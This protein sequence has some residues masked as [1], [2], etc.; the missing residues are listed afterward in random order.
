MKKIRKRI[1]KYVV[2]LLCFGI[3]VLVSA[4][5]RAKEKEPVSTARMYL[6]AAVNAGNGDGYS[7][8]NEIDIDD[9]HYNWKLGEFY[10]GGFTRVID[11]KSGSPIFLKNVGDKVKL[12]FI[13]NQDIDKLNGNDE[14]SIEQDENGYDEHFGIPKT[15]FGKGMLVIRHTNYQH[16]TEEPVLHKNYLESVKVKTDTEV[17]LCEEGDYEVALDYEIDVDNGIQFWKQGTYDYRIYFKFS[18]RNG[19]CMVYPFDTVNK[20]ELTNTSVTENGFYLDL[21][22]SK[23]LDIN[24][25]K[26]VLKEG[27]EGLVEDTRFNM[28]ASD[29]ESYT[30]EGVYTITAKNRYTNQTTTKI[31]YVGT[32]DLLKAHVTTNL[33]LKEIKKQMAQGAKINAD[34]SINYES[35]DIAGMSMASETEEVTFLSRLLKIVRMPRVWIVIGSVFI[36]ILALCFI[37]K[38]KNSRKENDT[39]ENV[40]ESEANEK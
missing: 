13:L 3:I 12:S 33:S 37:K 29:G 30:D 40:A 35:A 36:L 28:P 18:V 19:N 8:K 16:K 1:C 7:E 38:E 39:K 5:V 31:I 6:G 22:K 26:E 15:D 34:G 4:N 10:V 23:Y 20:N 25:K 11:E 21:A 2:M 17:E 32:N 27:A 14:L 24:V 9:P